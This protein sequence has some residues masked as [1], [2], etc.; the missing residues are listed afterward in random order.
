M[1]PKWD[2]LLW[3]DVPVCIIADASKTGAAQEVA[4]NIRR[5]GKTMTETEARQILG[6]ADQSTWEEVLQVDL[7][8]TSPFYNVHICNMH[9]FLNQLFTPAEVRQPI[10][11][12]CKE[13]EL[14]SSIK[15]PSSERMSR[16]SLPK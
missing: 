1:L 5:A 9:M 14:L 15:S 8:L 4:Q 12:K 16:I 6:V 10:R 7:I 2:L 3:F 11:A 13:R